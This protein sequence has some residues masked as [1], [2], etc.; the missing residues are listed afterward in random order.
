MRASS[1][2][3]SKASLPAGSKE[4]QMNLRWM[5]A[6]ALLAGAW[7]AASA[8]EDPAA[9]LAQAKGCF[10][11]HAVDKKVVGPSYQDV[12]K[13]YAGQKNAVDTLSEKVVKGGSGVWG[14]VPMPPNQVSPAEARQLVEWVLKQK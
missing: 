6:A 1:H 3:F 4:L 10:A 12:A 5:M 13:K 14:Q 9:K 8:Q 7:V 2:V 11:C